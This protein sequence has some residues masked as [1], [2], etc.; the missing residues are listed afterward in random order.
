MLERSQIIL[1][2]SE[3]G[4][5]LGFAYFWHCGWIVFEGIDDLFHAI[6]PT[7]TAILCHGRRLL[8]LQQ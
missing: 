6:V 5:S 3:S 4:I 8:A 7:A 1:L 2:S